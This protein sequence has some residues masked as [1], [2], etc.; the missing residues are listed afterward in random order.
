MYTHPGLLLALSQG[1]SQDLL[2]SHHPFF[3][4]PHDQLLPIN[5]P[6]L[7]SIV[8]SS[9]VLEY[10]LGGEGD[11]FKA[12]EPIIGESVLALDPIASGMSLISD[13]DDVISAETIQVADMESIQIEH[14]NDVINECKKVFLAKSMTEETI[15]EHEVA[16]Q[17]DEEDSEKA[18]SKMVAEGEMQK[19]VSSGS[20][21]SIEWINACCNRRPDFLSFQGLDFGATLGMRR[22]FSEGD[23]QTLGSNNYTN[24]NCTGIIHSYKKS[25]ERREKLSRYRR[26]KSLRNFNRKIK[27]C[28]VFYILN[29]D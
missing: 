25:E 10:D 28:E 13:A 6:N 9:A 3:S 12:P 4:I 27:V 19:S 1:F 2:S 7:G 17:I 18:K 15:P 14:L 21:K 5:K 24:Y 11:L 8:Q 16:Q 26:K 22:A 23:I 29:Q 20:L